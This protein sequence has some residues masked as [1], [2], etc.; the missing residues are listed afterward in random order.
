MYVYKVMYSGIDYESWKNCESGTYRYE[1]GLIFVNK[2]E[3][4]LNFVQSAMAKRF[5]NFIF[6]SFSDF[7]EEQ[8]NEIEAFSVDDLHITLLDHINMTTCMPNVVGFNAYYDPKYCEHVNIDEPY[9]MCL[10]SFRGEDA[11]KKA[12]KLYKLIEGEEW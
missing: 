11:K 7:E 6:C 2:K 1:V 3:A 8:D 9:F 4:D 10:G 12:K 5:V